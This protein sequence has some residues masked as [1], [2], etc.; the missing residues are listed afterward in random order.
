M[1]LI[2]LILVVNQLVLVQK[3]ITPTNELLRIL[4]TIQ[5]LDSEKSQLIFRYKELINNGDW[6]IMSGVKII[7][8][9][10]AL[11]NDKDSVNI[12][13]KY[14][15]PLILMHMPETLKR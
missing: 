1:V 15:V 14:Q 10:S 6:S 3:K 13:K 9:V 5:L 11:T 2:L 8:D 4:P 12:I 7:N